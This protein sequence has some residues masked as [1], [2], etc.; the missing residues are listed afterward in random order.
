MGMRMR[1]AILDVG[2]G[3]GHAYTYGVHP[4]HSNHIP[5][6]PRPCPPSR[7]TEVRDGGK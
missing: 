1:M 2:I 3:L 4:F 6:P 5:D 7:D